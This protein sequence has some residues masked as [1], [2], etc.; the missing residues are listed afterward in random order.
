[1]SVFPHLFWQDNSMNISSSEQ[2]HGVCQMACCH[3]NPKLSVDAY[4]SN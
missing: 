3:A 1:M 2:R 4:I